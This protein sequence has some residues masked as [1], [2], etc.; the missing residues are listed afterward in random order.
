MNKNQ[1]EYVVEQALNRSVSLTPHG[2]VSALE[3][4]GVLKLEPEDTPLDAATRVFRN[5]SPHL[6]LE[7]RLLTAIRIFNRLTEKRIADNHR[8]VDSST[9]TGR[10][11][12]NE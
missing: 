7:H 2:L 6:S 3:K 5:A 4:L 9:W 10:G 1:A 12:K 8:T 11:G